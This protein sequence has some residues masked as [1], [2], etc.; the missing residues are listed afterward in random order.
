MVGNDNVTVDGPCFAC[1]IM[2][3]P[4]YYCYG[5]ELYICDTC[6]VN[7]NA[8]GFGHDP[9]DHLYDEFEGEWDDD[10]DLDKYDGYPEDEEDEDDD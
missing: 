8:G 10:D 5:C 4:E 9:E 2:A 6:A 1:G 3:G 7:M